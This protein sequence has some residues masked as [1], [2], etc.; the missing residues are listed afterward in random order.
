M[1]VG[2]K[3]TGRQIDICSYEAYNSGGGKQEK[4]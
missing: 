4:M 2:D 1:H 3:L